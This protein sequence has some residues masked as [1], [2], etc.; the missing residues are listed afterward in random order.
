MDAKAEDRV[1]HEL[2]GIQYILL[3]FHVVY[4]GTIHRHNAEF[5]QLKNMA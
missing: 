1:V 2:L 4:F 5:Q 3:E